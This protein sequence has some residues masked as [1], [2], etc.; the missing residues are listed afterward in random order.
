MNTGVNNVRSIGATLAE[1]KIELLDFL[2]TRIE[3]LKTELREKGKILKAAAPLGG[4]G[5]LLL[6]TAYLLFTL[7]VVSL[8]VVAFQDNPYRWFF[9]FLIVGFAWAVFGGIAVYFAKRKLET[10]TFLPQ[11]TIEVLKGD[12]IWIEAEVRNHV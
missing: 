9:A 4:L 2:D 10:E 12:K 6:G 8:V 11:R 3:L 1:M 5:A 7:A